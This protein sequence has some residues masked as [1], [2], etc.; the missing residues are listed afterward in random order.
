[1]LGRR[2]PTAQ[3]IGL[4]GVSARASPSGRSGAIKKTKVCQTIRDIQIEPKS[5][6]RLPVS[7]IAKGSRDLSKVRIIGEA[8][9]VSSNRIPN[10]Q[11]C[12]EGGRRTLDVI[13]RP[14]SSK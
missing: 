11:W 1:M 9:L 13:R 14:T 5:N 6:G 7:G 8:D 2:S 12:V 10:G 4:F 3:T